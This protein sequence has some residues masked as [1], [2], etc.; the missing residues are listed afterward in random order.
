MGGSKVRNRASNIITLCSVVNG[1]LESDADVARLGR[2]RGWKISGYEKP[3]EV[4]VYETWSG[5][6]WLLWDDGTRTIA[7]TVTD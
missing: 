6:W 3:E 1:L 5:L 7:K 4:A 2:E